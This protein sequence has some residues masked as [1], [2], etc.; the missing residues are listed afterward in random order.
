MISS[1]MAN[2]MD[3]SIHIFI[4]IP[5]MDEDINHPEMALIFSKLINIII[6]TQSNLNK[7]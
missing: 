3:T 1:W 7:L 6:S 5:Y 4:Y 2:F